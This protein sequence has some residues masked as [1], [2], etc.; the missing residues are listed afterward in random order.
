LALACDDGT[1]SVVIE[2]PPEPDA[3][4]EPEADA[5]A[6]ATTIGGLTLTTTPEEQEF[7]LFEDAGHHIWIEVNEEQLK[8]LNGGGGDGFPGPFFGDDIYSPGGPAIYADHFVVQEAGSGSVADYG[9]VEVKLVGE[10]TFRQWNSV[11][12]P[13][14]RVDA[15]EFQE[16]LRIGGYEHLRLN[17]SLVGSIFREG[18]AHRVYR[19]LGYPA[20]RSTFAFMGSNVW[21]EDVW[22]PMTLIEMYKK[23]FCKN[24]RELLGMGEDESCPNMWEFAGDVGGGG[25]GGG[26]IDFLL[27]EMGGL[28]VPPPAMGVGGGP[29]EIRVG[30][31]FQLQIPA[32]ACQ[33]SECD[34]TRLEEFGQALF[35]TPRGAGFKEALAPY[36][37]WTRYHQFQCLSWIL[38]TGD[39]P[40]HNSNN[41]LIIERED[42]RLVWAPYSIDI[43]AGQ[44]WYTNTPLIGQS[45]IPV[46]CQQDPECWA[47]TI[48]ECE[49]LI[50]AFDDLDPER[51]VDE[52]AELLDGLG[53][54]RDGDEERAEDLREWYL[55]RQEGL[56]DELERYRYLPD[57]N[58]ECP[59][60]L[61]ACNDGTCG[62]SEQCEE[63]LCSI[64][65]V[66]CESK[67]YCISPE[68]D[69]CPSCPASAPTWCDAN[70]SCV[71]SI[72]E[73]TWDCEIPG[74]VYCPLSESCLPEDECDFGGDGEGDGDGDGDPDAG[75][76]PEAG[77]E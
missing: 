55:T 70:Q 46:A 10:S 34:N 21:G 58:G 76:F 5:A 29:G 68:W 54:M 28:D 47:D 74:W 16:D 64:W 6:P 11:S 33:V 22:V 40:I 63:R 65:E 3:G 75:V 17:N 39:D 24:N 53:M 25:G 67:G 12:I 35:E 31:G 37:D 45:T 1:P 60:D 66:W 50:D 51:F 30:E 38:W 2:E 7:D 71:A 73:C 36:I 48:A 56:I 27:G 61:E 69:F 8:R 72:D 13:N 14:V 62:T 32:N 59:Q 15:D 4:P 26:P 57:A 49:K 18:I 43:S 44:D 23:K 20:L 77:L 41:N 19:E 52:T 9:Q 42:G